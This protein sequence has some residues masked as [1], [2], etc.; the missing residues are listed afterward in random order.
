MLIQ[1]LDRVFRFC[2]DR[3]VRLIEKFTQTI[4]NPFAVKRILGHTFANIGHLF[5]AS[6][7]QRDKPLNLSFDDMFVTIFQFDLSG[8]I[9][10]KTA[11][12]LEV[13]R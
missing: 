1:G 2:L 13:N 12:G 5:R 7:A 10:V 3:I 6:I 4:T 11:I 9:F 8:E